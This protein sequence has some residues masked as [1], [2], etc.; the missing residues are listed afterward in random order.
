MDRWQI[1]DITVSRVLETVERFMEPIEMFPDATEEAIEP[2][3]SWLVPNA[4]CPKTN[5]YILP[6]QGYL[7][8]TD[9]HTILIDTC[10]GNDKTCNWY[11]PWHQ[12]NSNDFLSH[13]ARVGVGP[14]QIDF[15]LCTHLHADHCGW[16]TRLL[17]GR[18]EPTFPNARYVMSREEYRH[19][20]GS[21][22]DDGDRAFE[23]SVL[24]IV[25]A[26]QHDL[27]DMDYALDDQVWLEP[28]PG[29]TP[30]HVSVRLRSQG[31]EAVMSGDLIH[32]PIQCIYPEWN[33]RY[34]SDPEQARLTRRKF[35]E[36]CCDAGPL[37]LTSHFPIP[38]VGCV[39]PQ[40][41]AFW[42]EYEG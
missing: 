13:L 8:R 3:L 15:V 28:T 6:I 12:R 33:Y 21:A 30:G 26:G 22:G 14:E 16:N 31:Q 34:D 11:E 17:N 20:E 18:W 24:P 19:S 25:E 29:H 42:F 41:D 9:H 37:V 7:L 38:S 27:V 32:C 1:G 23:E 10:V 36:D 35:L 40:G 5:K 2:H 39:I 4:L